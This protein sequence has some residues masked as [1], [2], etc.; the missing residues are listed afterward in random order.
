MRSFNLNANLRKRSTDFELS[1]FLPFFTGTENTS[2]D[3]YGFGISE[4]LQESLTAL[5]ALT[6]ITALLGNILLIYIIR[7]RRPLTPMSILIVN[8]AASDLLT[9]LF[10][11]PYSAAFLYVQTHWFGGI[12]GKIT[13]KLLHVVIGS[14][15][16]SSIFTL[17]AISAERHI[18]V[19]KPLWYPAF[20]RRPFCYQFQYGF[21]LS[22]SCAHFSSFM[23]RPT[24][25]DLIAMQTGKPFLTMRIWVREY[26]IPQLLLSFT[27]YLFLPLLSRRWSLWGSWKTR[28]YLFVHF[29][30][31]QERR[32]LKNE[33]AT[34]CGCFWPSLYFL[35]FVGF[36]FISLDEK[37]DLPL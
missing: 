18:A 10:T 36:L 24:S 19:V 35:Q 22:Y 30:I 26:S 37:T 15:I 1:F 3:S 5:Y 14:T 20:T 12:A 2:L 32:T 31:P 16:A 8:M 13:C 17:L 29:A 21:C 34:S 9:A 23:C 4:T 6:F 25:M 33:I 27:F 28:K 7:Q 11:M